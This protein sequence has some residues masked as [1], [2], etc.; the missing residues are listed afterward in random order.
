MEET[1]TF[2]TL[3][4]RRDGPTLH[5]TF[6]RPEQRNA[7]NG[8]MS[9][10]L[11]RVVDG[12]VCDKSIRVIVLRGAGGNFCA[13][14]DIKERRAEAENEGG[15]QDPL[16]ERNRRAGLLFRKFERLPQTTI[17]LVE[18][19]AFGGG[20]GYACLTDITIVAR[21]ARLG[22]PE[23]SIGVAPAQIAPFVVRRI[24]LTR[25]RQLAL[26]AERFDGAKALEYGLAHY[27]GED[28]QMD[29]LLQDVI[30]KILR[31][32]PEANAATKRIM[33]AVGTMPEDELIRH[34]AEIF[35]ELNRGAEGREGQAA[36]A[37]KRKPRWQV[38]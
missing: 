2:D 26:T 7:I 4:L 33:L 29:T 37:E 11:A 5:V 13:G 14:G 10:E 12:V 16:M 8:Q 38:V 35:A 15:A 21:N 22:M 30:A 31:C 24:G 25:A 18:G 6:N 9:R 23:T 1:T 34:S 27:L 36:F 19:A 32:G 3:L 28:H 20:L 17:A